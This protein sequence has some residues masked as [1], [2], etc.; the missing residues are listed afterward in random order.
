MD[1]RRQASSSRSIWACATTRSRKTSCVRRCPRRVRQRGRARGD[2]GAGARSP[3]RSTCPGAARAS[4]SARRRP[5]ETAALEL[6]DGAARRSPISARSSGRSR[7]SPKG[8]CS[9]TT[10]RSSPYHPA[11]GR[12][13][14]AGHEAVSERHR[15]EAFLSASGREPDDSA[16]RTRS[17]V[18]RP[19]TTARRLIGGNLDDAAL[20]RR[21]SRR[22]RR[23]PGSRACGRRRLP[24]TSR[25]TST[26]PRASASRRCSTSPDGFTTSSRRSAPSAC[27]R[28]RAREACTSICRFRRRRRTK[29]ACCF[30]QIIATVVASKHPKHATIERSRRRPRSPRV[31]GLPPEHHGQDAGV[32]VQR[33][34]QRVRRRLDAAHL[35][36]GRA[37]RAA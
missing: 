7:S 3:V 35:G 18:S 8:I 19:R 26:R 14:S 2:E 6:P 17:S 16:G 24:T 34:R 11:G 4:A 30:C 33:A 22:S 13:S 37:R 31:R 29:R 1:G 10:C 25:W 12:R 27:P 15:R 36:R 9:A 32:S 5:G 20:L 28:R 23:T 21:S